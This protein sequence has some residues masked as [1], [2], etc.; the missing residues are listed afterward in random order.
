ML[1]TMAEPLLAE[2][3][4]CEAA[5]EQGAVYRCAGDDE[6]LAVDPALGAPPDGCDAAGLTRA[7]I[8]AAPL[9]RSADLVGC[10][11]LRAR[12]FWDATDGGVLPGLPW[13]ASFG[14]AA[15]P[16]PELGADTDTI[17]RLVADRLVG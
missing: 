1:W 5:Q 12:G 10:P 11:H 2:Q 9:A 15:G 6:W 17:L 13:R 3:G 4:A 8:A 16:A 7:G 14:R